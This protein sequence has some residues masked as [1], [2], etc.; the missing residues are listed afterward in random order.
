[1]TEI[2]KLDARIST[3]NLAIDAVNA[4]LVV[5]RKLSHEKHPSGH[6]T[7]AI[8]ALLLARGGLSALKIRLETIGR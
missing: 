3:I 5:D 8:N 4:A 7:K 6:F 2:E 1:M